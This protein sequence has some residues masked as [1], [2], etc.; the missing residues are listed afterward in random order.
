M[1]AAI[2]W[3]NQQSAPVVAVDL[4]SGVDASSGRIPGVAV[5]AALTVTFAFPKVG[6]VSYPGAG[7]AGEVI[8][9]PIGIPAALATAAPGEFQLIDAAAA[10]ALLPPRPADGPLLLPIDRAFTLKGFGT[11]VTGTLLSG[12]LS[13]EAHVALLPAPPGGPELRVRSLQVHSRPTQKALAGQRTAVNLPGVEPAAIARGYMSLMNATPCPMNTLSSIVT[14]SHTNVWLE[15]LHLA[16]TLAFFW[17]ST[18]VPT[19]LSSPIS[20]P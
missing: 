7:Q 6:L 16:P 20:Q 17:I 5:K 4:P 8:T 9:V 13:E 18:K 15:I 2:D 1:A 10:R 3:L 12:S 11:V 14:P 19:R